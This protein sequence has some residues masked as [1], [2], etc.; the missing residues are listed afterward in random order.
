MLMFTLPFAITP[1]Y[2]FRYER[3]RVIAHTDAALLRQML[4][5]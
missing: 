2:L 3:Q 1:R 4:L 5:L